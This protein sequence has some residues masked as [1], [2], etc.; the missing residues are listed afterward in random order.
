ML[1]RKWSWSGKL[2]ASSLYLLFIAAQAL[3]QRTVD[4]LFGTLGNPNVCGD[5][6]VVVTL[7]LSTPL[8]ASDSLLLFEFAVAYDPTKMEFVAPLFSGTLAENADYSGSG[9]IDSATVRIYAFNITRPFR[10]QG[11]LA[12]MLFRY[13]NS[14]PDTTSLY[15]AYEPEKNPEAKI[16]YG[17]LGSTVVTAQ[18]RPQLEGSLT[19]QFSR[20]TFEVQHGVI[21]V[22]PLE[23][24]V[25]AGTRLQQWTMTIAADS[26]LQIRS[27]RLTA[28]DSLR[29]EVVEQSSSHVK[30]H[31]VGPSSLPA[32]ALSLECEVQWASY[33]AQTASIMVEIE[34]VSCACVTA[35]RGDTAIVRADTITTVS[36]SSTG[37]FWWLY[38]PAHQVWKLC[39]P[40]EQVAAV[41]HWDRLG[42]KIQT[43]ASP[44]PPVMI[45]AAD[46]WSAVALILRNGNVVRT[47][48]VR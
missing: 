29:L 28:V 26:T 14:C 38:V 16:Q 40:V 6:S 36:E 32:R 20:D 24:T 1:L 22:V 17:A 44:S 10:G 5:R 2:L 25:P 47:I 7:S 34:P 46:R 39:G 8:Y 12:G 4:V 13:R 30:V 41:V 27:V 31:V 42:R 9:R 11:P 48:L 33:D 21:G 19:A 3:A 43:I 35:V 37:A 18:E 45:D 23:V 15:L